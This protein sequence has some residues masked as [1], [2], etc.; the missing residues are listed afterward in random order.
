MRE[1]HM[2]RICPSCD[3]VASSDRVT[4]DHC[5]SLTVPKATRAAKNDERPREDF[6]RSSHDDPQGPPPLS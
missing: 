2:Q 6:R 5:G 1:G 3:A 4:C